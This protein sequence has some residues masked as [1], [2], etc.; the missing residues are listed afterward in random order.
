MRRASSKCVA[1][2]HHNMMVSFCFPVRMKGVRRGPTAHQVTLCHASQHSSTVLYRGGTMV[3]YRGGTMVVDSSTS[4]DGARLTC[5]TS[6][7]LYSIFHFFLCVFPFLCSCFHDFTF[8]DPASWAVVLSPCYTNRGL[9]NLRS[10]C[11]QRNLS[12]SGCVEASLSGRRK[13]KG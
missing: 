7:F 12:I 5:S 2:I 10:E 11:T 1:H 3:L 8:Q 9:T 6:R 4:A 13:A